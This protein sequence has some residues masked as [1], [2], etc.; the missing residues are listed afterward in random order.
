MEIIFVIAFWI[1][2]NSL[3]GYWIGARKNCVGAAVA[4]SIL[5]GPI[6]WILVIFDPGGMRRC[7]FCAED[8]KTEAEVCRFCQRDLPALGSP[9]RPS[10]HLLEFQK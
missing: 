9:R 1:G 4:L 3:V 10:I 6:G 7:P 5:L 8:V 2:V